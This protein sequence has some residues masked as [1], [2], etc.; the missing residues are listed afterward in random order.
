[1]N[2]SFSGDYPIQNTASKETFQTINS[3]SNPSALNLP[4][5][6][7]T[8]KAPSPHAKITKEI[9]NLTELNRDKYNGTSS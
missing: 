8:H 9:L 5:I 1:M 7:Q 4:T 3:T 2:K 6:S